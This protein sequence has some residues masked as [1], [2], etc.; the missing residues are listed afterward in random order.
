MR[1]A[2]KAADRHDDK[3]KID[4]AQYLHSESIALPSPQ[5]KLIKLDEY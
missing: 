1:Q 5:I 3:G 4:A 2:D